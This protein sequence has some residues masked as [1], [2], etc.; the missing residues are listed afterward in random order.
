MVDGGYPDSGLGDESLAAAGAIV[1]G[2]TC[3]S[4]D[5]LIDDEADHRRASA[6]ERLRIDEGV[7]DAAD[8]W[9]EISELVA[10]SDTIVDARRALTKPP[11]NYAAMVASHVLDTPLRRLSPEAR[12]ELTIE[13]GEIRAYL[14]ASQPD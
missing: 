14:D 2:L 5:R 8:R 11:F 9:R 7:L 10:S 12:S 4:D 3:V 13:V 1:E 6:E